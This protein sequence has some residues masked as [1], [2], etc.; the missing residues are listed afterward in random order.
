MLG[1][2][3]GAIG[4]LVGS[5]FGADKAKDAA[6]EQAALQREFAQNGIR[7]KVEDAKAAG[8]HPLYAL[9]A[10][11]T[12]YSPVTV[13]GADW[14][15]VGQ[16]IG[17]AIGAMTT[18]KEKADGFA[19]T[20][21]DLTLQKMGLE[22]EVLASQLRMINQ[23][24]RGPGMPGATLIPGQGSTGQ[25]IKIAGNTV[26]I[27]NNTS[28]AQVGEDRYGEIGGEVIGGIAAV[29]DALKAI[30]PYRPG[31]AS[32]QEKIYRQNYKYRNHGLSEPIPSRF[33]R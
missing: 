31:K 32:T 24:G 21:Q 12:A 28:D 2:A 33:A 4:S 27:D 7:W 22:N 15:G 16:N 5:I 19:K 8:I 29:S 20:V 3:I 11:T 9:G 6:R 30:E 25:T 26:Q 14:G 23:P 18:P 1:A 17:S 10:Q 13:G